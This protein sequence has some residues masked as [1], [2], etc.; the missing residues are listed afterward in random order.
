MVTKKTYVC[1][2]RTQHLNNNDSGMNPYILQAAG[3]WW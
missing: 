3:Q 2:E 1:T